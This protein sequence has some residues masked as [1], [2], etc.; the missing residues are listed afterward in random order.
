MNYFLTL[1]EHRIPEDFEDIEGSVPDHCDKANIVIKCYTTFL[2][3]HYTQKYIEPMLQST[4]C[5]TALCLKK[6]VYIP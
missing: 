3:S 2:L 1:L 6:T 5:A 4:E